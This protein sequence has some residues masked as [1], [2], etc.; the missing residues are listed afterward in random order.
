M[1]FAEYAIDTADACHA[2]GV[3]TVAVTAGYIGAG[4]R[5]SSSRKMDAANVD[6]KAFTDDFYVKLCGAH[7]AP[8]LDTLVAIRPRDRRLARDHDAADPGQERLRRRADGA[9]RAGS[10]RELG[11]DVPLHFTAFHPD[12][13]MTDVAADAAGDAAGARAASR[14]PRGCTTS[15]PATST[16]ARAAPRFCPGCGAPLIER[17][18][19]EIRALRPDARGRVPALRHRAARALRHGRRAAGIAADAGAPRR[20]FLTRGG[21]TRAC[22]R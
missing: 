21:A 14:S 17:D 6:L 8:V 19:Y 9:V 10:R 20:V 12:Y 1:I 13:K 18:G 11:P 5:A 2:R 7:L 4:A 16:T 15:T 22:A 3:E